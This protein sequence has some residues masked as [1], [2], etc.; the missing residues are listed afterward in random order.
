MIVSICSATL[1]M[2]QKEK[3]TQILK[4]TSTVLPHLCACDSTLH[5]IKNV[6]HSLFL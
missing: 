3:I 6:P 4:K 2:M 5:Q 1:Y